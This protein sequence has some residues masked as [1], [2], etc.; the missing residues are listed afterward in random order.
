MGYSIAETLINAVICAAC[1][2]F[3]RPRRRQLVVVRYERG[4][5]TSVAGASGDAPS[6]IA[7]ATMQRDSAQHEKV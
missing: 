3:F 1:L 5:G 7:C 6:L 2:E 4:V